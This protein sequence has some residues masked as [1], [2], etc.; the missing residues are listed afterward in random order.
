VLLKDRFE[1]SLGNAPTAAIAASKKKDGKKR[2][3]K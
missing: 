3:V 2:G 1:K